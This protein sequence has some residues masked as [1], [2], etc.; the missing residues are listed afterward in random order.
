MSQAERIAAKRSKEISTHMIAIGSAI[1]IGLERAFG[2]GIDLIGDVVK[3]TIEAEKAQ[4]QL[5]QAFKTSGGASGQSL[6]SLRDTAEALQ[7]LTGIDDDAIASV[8]TLLLQFRHIS[9]DTFPEATKAVLDFS[10]RMGTDL[11]AA[12]E[13]VGKALENPVNGLKA[14]KAA[15]VDL[16]ESQQETIKHL[17]DTGHAADAQKIVLDELTKSIGGAAEAARGTLGGSL[18]ALKV[19]AEN[20]L[21]GDSGGGGMQGLVASIN[22]LNATLN[23]PD[24]K[25]GIQSMIQGL[26][27][28]AQ[29]AVKATAAVGGLA[30][31]V[32][33]H[34]LEDAQK[35][36][37][38]LL[39]R[40]V[41]LQ[42]QIDR[43]GSKN[44]TWRR[45]LGIGD[46]T[47]LAAAKKELSDINHQI[48]LMNGLRDGQKFGGNDNGGTVEIHGGALFGVGNT[49]G[50]TA[51]AGHSAAASAARDQADA[52]RDLKQQA[53]A[54]KQAM[55]DLNSILQD[56]ASE[57]GGPAV[58]AGIAYRDTM[59]KIMESEDEL[60]K[61]G[62]LDADAQGEIALARDQATESYQRH[63]EAIQATKS[64]LEE[65]LAQ[66]KH[67]LD[68]LG[69]TGA[70][71]QT[72][73]DLYGKSAEEVAKYGAAVAENNNQI[74]A[75]REQLSEMQTFQDD[76]EGAF[77]SFLDG[78][79][80]AKEAFS[81]LA[82]SVLA[83]IARMLAH[84]WAEQL[85][86]S[87]SG[88]GDWL[89]GLISAFSSSSG[90]GY[91]SMVGSGSAVS[92][93]G[94]RASGGPVSAGK[95]YEVTEHSPELLQIGNRTMLMMGKQGGHVTPM[96]SGNGGQRA[97]QVNQ[98]IAV[99]GKMD[100]RSADQIARATWREGMRATRRI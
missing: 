75:T 20:L 98:T 70:A 22:E 25:S 71:L 26:A 47:E 97:I 29:F 11:P 12:A 86:N 78:S 51:G 44:G 87:G 96:G 54:L 73:N 60:R 55:G 84:K 100:R 21:E 7:G 10:A 67:E 33:Q 68:T 14:L 23:D 30:E 65:L 88:S 6:K 42:A 53:D 63:I 85:F 89:S 66:Q 99:Q 46:P 90:G 77:A 82:K 19:S 17:V 95:M 3:A 93:G 72:A 61:Q 41:E 28:V 64:P 31:I 83:D 18:A 9:G 58:D 2:A 8:Q 49:G 1:G 38:G 59:V 34:F 50:H 79:K 69:L 39:D 15:G 40:T 35:S 94:G 56:Q 52:D 5:A 32:H 48:A 4:A 45:S 36:Y 62:K 27:K 24:I 81:D 13:A 16:S 92:Y 43:G 80:S 37:N 76:F 74:E 91:A 57:M